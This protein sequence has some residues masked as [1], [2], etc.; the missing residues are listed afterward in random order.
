MAA[1]GTQAAD[2]CGSQA[3]SP[4]NWPWPHGAPLP[5][6]RSGL[7]MAPTVRGLAP[8]LATDQPVLEKP[9]D[10][11]NGRLTDVELPGGILAIVKTRAS[12]CAKPAPGWFPKPRPNFLG[13][14]ASKLPPADLA[15]QEKAGC[16]L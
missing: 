13:N 5:P 12:A 14:R 3:R 8:S 16:G 10:P 2:N 11:L 7:T 9:T 1:A 6:A 4:K 15:A